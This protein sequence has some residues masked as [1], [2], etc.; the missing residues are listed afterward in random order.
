MRTF[1]VAESKVNAKR[2]VESSGLLYN[3]Q[4]DIE[5]GNAGYVVSVELIL[6]N[7]II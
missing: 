5:S 1:V 2:K 4:F 6:Y 3:S 7:V